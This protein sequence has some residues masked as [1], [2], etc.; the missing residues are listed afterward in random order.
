MYL[1]RERLKDLR[2]ELNLDQKEMGE[3]LNLSASAYG[4]YEQGRN[5]PSLQTLIKIAQTFN[6]TTDY[7]L[8]L[9]N[10][11]ET[12]VYYKMS[13][14]ILL[15]NSEMNAIQKMKELPLLEEVSEDPSEYVVRLN[16]YWQFIKNERDNK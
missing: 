12:S 3:K 1:F 14:K 16:R 2:D 7:L 15:S 13:D 4:Y 11:R 5:E 9:T 8:G 10:T 6:V